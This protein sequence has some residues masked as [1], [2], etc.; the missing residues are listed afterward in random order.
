MNEYY[1]QAIDII[2]TEQ[3]WKSICA[4]VAKKDPKMFCEAC[5]KLPLEVK[6]K[7]I[8]DTEGKIQAIKYVRSET[9]NSLK[10]AK[11]IVDSLE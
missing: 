4:A 10:D 3:N 11:D 8:L 9:G 1:R 7:N 2:A 6:A 5:G